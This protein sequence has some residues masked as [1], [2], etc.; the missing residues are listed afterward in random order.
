MTL[1]VLVDMNLSPEWIDVLVHGGMRAVHC[2]KVGNPQATDLEIMQ[3]AIEN[4][5][6]ILTHDLDFGTALALTR[7]IGPSIL[8]IRTQNML[9][10]R[11]GPLVLA[12][13]KEHRQ[14]IQEGA[15]VVVDQ[16]RSRVRVLPLK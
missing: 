13:I 1:A 5:H 12:A 6:A 11:I 2:S 16:V 9:P 8:Q 3:W 4:S 10:E 14:T 7:A 15:L